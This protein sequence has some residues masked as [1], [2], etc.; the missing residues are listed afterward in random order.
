MAP[1][2]LS[3][4]WRDLLCSAQ[5]GQSE[6]V[7]GRSEQELEAI[8]NQ[9]ERVDNNYPGGVLSY[10]ERARKLL[11][12]SKNSVN[13]LQGYKPSLPPS[14]NPEIGSE[15]F[16][17]LEAKGERCMTKCAFILVAGGL[18][19]R[20]QYD[21]IKIGLLTNITVEM[22]YIEYYFRC[23]RQIELSRDESDP[24]T[25]APMVIM[26]SSDT[27]DK[28]VRLLEEHDYYGLKKEQIVILQQERVPALANNEALMAFSE[29]A[30]AIQMKPHGHGDVHSLIH[31]AGLP[32]KWIAEG[33]E[34]CFFFQDTNALALRAMPVLLGISADR[35]FH[36]NSLCIPRYPQEAVGAICKLERADGK[37]PMTLNIEYNVLDALLKSAGLG[38]DVPS[39]PDSK[40][41]A[42]PGNCNILG[43]QL[44][45]YNNLLKEGK[46]AV[47]EFVNPKYADSSRSKFKSPTRLECM[48]QEFAR[49][50]KDPN[51]VGCTIL[52][53]WF[54]FST[55]KNGLAVA[56][57]KLDAGNSPEC[58]FSAESDLY[59]ANV[60]CLRIACD[61]LLIK[62]SCAEPKT[63]EFQGIRYPLGPRLFIDPLFGLTIS[64][65]KSKL[66]KGAAK[67][68]SIS[69]R[70]SVG[71]IGPAQFSALCVDGS[72]RIVAP[73]GGI[74]NLGNV[75]I[76]NEG[77]SLESVDVNDKNVPLNYRVR[78]YRPAA[79]SGTFIF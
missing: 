40:Y 30:G 41:S 50:Y 54:C 79:H 55:V 42:F 31:A 4:K 29:E 10:L 64:Q 2:L 20:L 3:N 63:V 66:Q 74:T 6:L 17:R 78:G 5:Y 73:I 75:T 62:C 9:L 59:Q 1:S 68:V 58:A 51:R 32:P 36:F 33:Y 76:K 39:S 12:D 37:Q 26:T 43:L 72:L 23:I 52:D 56:K 53:R 22:T 16:F 61:Q 35:D 38:G 57:Q 34:W 77:V 67:E 69:D 25:P 7:T 60:Q 21:D 47:P 46:G 8:A 11:E 13:P 18:G 65:I 27:H 71:I 15:E 14:V 49:L 70:S 28:T 45:P 19:E 48:M 44:K 24:K